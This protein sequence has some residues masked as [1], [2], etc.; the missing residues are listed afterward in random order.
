MPSRY[1][2]ITQLIWNYLIYIN[3][4]QLIEGLF[5]WHQ[6]DLRWEEQSAIITTIHL[7]CRCQE[8][9]VQISIDARYKYI[10]QAG[11]ASKELDAETNLYYYGRRYYNSCRGQ[12]LQIDPMAV[13]HTGW[14]PYN[15]TYANPVCYIDPNGKD[16]LNINLP[17]NRKQEGTAA[18][19]VNGKNIKLKGG[20]NV[21]GEGTKRYPTK[22]NG[23]T[24]TG[25]A[26]VTSSAFWTK[27]LLRFNFSTYTTW[28]SS[29]AAACYNSFYKL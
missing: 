18:L 8:K 11:Q 4:N 1:D 6:D 12:W 28:V 15:Y 19:I 2:F 14:S 29:L 20:Y 16:T 9:I 17:K 25:T 7:E 27:S 5:R 26:L 24:P 10:P 23:D 21:L 13:F 22:T 3:P